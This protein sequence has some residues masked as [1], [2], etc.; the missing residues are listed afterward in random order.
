MNMKKLIKFLPERFQTI[1]AIFYFNMQIR[2]NKFVAN[3]YE[4]DLLDDLLSEG[5]IAIDVG[6]NIGRYTSKMAKIVGECGHV[7]SIEPM[8]RTFAIL[9]ILIYLNGF[10]NISLINMAASNNFSFSNFEQDWIE[11]NQNYLFH[12]STK[13]HITNSTINK[14]C[15]T[16]ITFKFDDIN[17]NKKV[18]L[19]KIDVEGMEY[20]VCMGLEKII[21]KYLPTLIIEN[22]SNKVIQLLQDWGYESYHVKSSSRN[23]IFLHKSD[24]ARI[25]KMLEKNVI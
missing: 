12:T 4:W 9:S 20:N 10:K 25:L 23:L 21:R 6:A 7:I 11:L 5:D 8:P 18:K 17:F 3:E 2:S 22:N 15:F 24:N 1:L 16:R 14:N 13:S 19:I